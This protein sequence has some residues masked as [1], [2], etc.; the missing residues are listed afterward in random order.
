[1]LPLPQLVQSQ[2]STRST[3]PK[4][5]AHNRPWT[6]RRKLCSCSLELLLL[7]GG[8]L[9]HVVQ[10]P[11]HQIVLSLQLPQL[12]LQA[13]HIG[14]CHQ[15]LPWRQ[16]LWVQIQ[17]LLIVCT[18]FCGRRSASLGGRPLFSGR[19]WK[20]HTSSPPGLTILLLE[21]VG[22]RLSDRALRLAPNRQRAAV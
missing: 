5:D 17:H 11:L 8:H 14:L 7:A 19:R 22:W 1:M 16:Q 15:G 21:L 6:S 18:A 20:P 3:L 9:A 4:A 12:G 13:G 2:G 10:L